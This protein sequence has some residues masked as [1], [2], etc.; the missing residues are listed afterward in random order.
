MPYPYDGAG[1]TWARL[2][3]HVRLWHIQTV[4]PRNGLYTPLP[5]DADTAAPAPAV[6]FTALDLRRSFPPD[7]S[8]ADRTR[9]SLDKSWLLEHV[10]LARWAPFGTRRRRRR[11][12]RRCPAASRSGAAGSRCGTRDSPGAAGRPTAGDAHE[13]LGELELAYLLFAL[14]HA[15]EGFEQWK[16]LV[17]LFCGCTDAIVRHPALFAAFAGTAPDGRDRERER[18][19][20]GSAAVLRT[21]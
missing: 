9:H 5:D 21:L 3:G 13:V 8:P 18:A 10:L 6:L 12:R 17:L 11:L 19:W 15:F 20:T 2:S 14:G 1:A 4:L 7:A 16:R